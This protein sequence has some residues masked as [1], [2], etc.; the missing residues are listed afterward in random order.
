MDNTVYPPTTRAFNKTSHNTA[1]PSIARSSPLKSLSND[2]VSDSEDDSDEEAGSGDEDYFQ[3]IGLE[4]DKTLTVDVNP[5]KH[6]TFR[7]PGTPDSDSEAL[8]QDDH[9]HPPIPTRKTMRVSP[10]AKKIIIEEV[11]KERVKRKS[12]Y[13]DP[14]DPLR[15]VRHRTYLDRHVYR[16]DVEA[17][18]VI[19]TRPPS[20]DGEDNDLLSALGKT[21]AVQCLTIG[22]KEYIPRTAPAFTPITGIESFVFSKS[23][24][25]TKD[26][27]R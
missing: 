2:L 21:Q 17:S 13:D 25:E 7:V 6:S 26:G 16:S 27:E 19:S 22:S 23:G 1:S 12:R 3:D 5:S 14:D 9:L 8:P 4:N 18:V 15:P 11:H 10:G 20:I 24:M